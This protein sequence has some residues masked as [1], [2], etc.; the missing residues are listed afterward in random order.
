MVDISQNLRFLLWQDEIL[1]LQKRQKVSKWPERTTKWCQKLA[2]WAECDFLRAEA[3]LK[4]AKISQAEL[5]NIKHNK[6]LNEDE[7]IAITNAD[8]LHLQLDNQPLNIWQENVLFLLDRLNHGDKSK[9][10]KVLNTSPSNFS[11]WK[12]KIHTPEI[13]YKDIIH[14]FFNIHSHID[15]EKDPLFLSIEPIDVP[16]I[17]LWLCQK[18]QELPEK[19]LQDFFPA[20]KRLLAD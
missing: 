1:N 10:A 17:K 15:L 16:E 14:N 7:F 6:P 3:I 4:G 2:F 8:M 20:L 5:N 11:R 9:L 19:T 18:I 12:K 13:T